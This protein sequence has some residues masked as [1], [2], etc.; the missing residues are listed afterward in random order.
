MTIQELKNVI[1]QLNNMWQ[2]SDAPG[3]VENLYA[4]DSLY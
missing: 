1:D 2:E 3:Q 4:Q